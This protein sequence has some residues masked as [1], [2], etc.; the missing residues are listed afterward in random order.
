MNSITKG[1]IIF[2]NYS[3]KYRE[4]LP[5]VIKDISLKI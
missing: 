2:K 3:A 5:L 4:G 1:N